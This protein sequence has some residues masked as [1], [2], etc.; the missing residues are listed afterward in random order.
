MFHSLYIYIYTYKGIQYVDVYQSGECSTHY[1]Y[2]CT[3][4]K[5]YNMLMYTSVLNV[6]LTIHVH[7]YI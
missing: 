7:V 3:H 5:V 2:T 1:T 4:I 6:P